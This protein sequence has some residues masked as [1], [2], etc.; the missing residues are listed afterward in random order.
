M[1]KIVR[2][3]TKATGGITPEEKLRR[4]AVAQEWIGIAMR[5]R[6]IDP[7]KII[8]A[9]KGIYAAAKLKEPRVVIVPSPLVMAFA[10]GAAAWIWYCRKQATDQATDQATVQATEQATCQA[11]YRETYQA[12]YQ[13]TVQATDQAIYQATEQA[14]YQATDQA[15]YQAT[16]Q[17]THAVINNVEAS[18][19][20]CKE[21]AGDGGLTCVKRWWDSYQGGN[22]WAAWT[23]YI[24]AFRDVL[25]LRLPEHA[26]FAH[27]EEAAR[28]GGFRVMHEDFCMVSDFP[29]V[30]KKD[31]QN[32]PHCEDGPSHLWRDGWAMYHWHGVRV[33]DEWITDRKSL[34]ATQALA[35][36]N[37]ELR[38]AACEIVGWAK[39]LKDLKAKTINID[40]P[41]IG[42]LLEVNLPES[43]KEKF[44]RVMCATGREFAI[45]VPR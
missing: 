10:Y 5:T 9:I 41:Q 20:A 31:E 16:D 44:L 35:Q 11:T 29:A 27:Y 32:R 3:P 4:D 30:L 37:T 21:L 7:E 40:A 17:A 36:T 43:G 34:T 25:G 38:R 28:E 13:A 33:P 22:M 23:S 6:P 15:T 2:T 1:A 26:A 39:I 19:A 24:C 14:A 42:T 18:A 8:P 45:P 12:T